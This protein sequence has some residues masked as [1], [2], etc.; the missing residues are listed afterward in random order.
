MLSMRFGN[1]Y[2]HTQ[3]DIS[4]RVRHP[5][6]VALYDV[7]DTSDKLYLVMEYIEGGE[8]FDRIVDQVCI[9]GYTQAL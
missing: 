2:L 3:V 5:H 7:Y 9:G 6:I 8:L 1:L 4:R